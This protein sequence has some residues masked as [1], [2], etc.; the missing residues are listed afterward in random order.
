MI[1]MVSLGGWGWG[2]GVD[3]IPFASSCNFL[4][5]KLWSSWSPF[6]CGKYYYLCVFFI[7]F[8]SVSDPALSCSDFLFCWVFAFRRFRPRKSSG[9]CCPKRRT[10]SAKRMWTIELSSLQPQRLS[11]YKS[12]FSICFSRDFW[13][14]CLSSDVVVPWYCKYLV[15]TFFFHLILIFKTTIM[16]IILIRL[17]FE[18]ATIT[19]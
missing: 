18:S 19:Y 12:R 15:W 3:A 11:I 7:S 14:N 16:H 1:C 6:A 8:V 5:W 9:W 17:K 13:Y 4:E 10:T 2:G